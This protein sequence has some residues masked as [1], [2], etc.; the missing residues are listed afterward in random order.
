MEEI[1]DDVDVRSEV[2]R[3]FMDRPPSWL[4]RWGTLSLCVVL[5]AAFAIS[6]F[7]HYPTIVRTDFRLI[8]SNLPKAVLLKTDGRIE[9]LFVKENQ[10]VKV[11]EILAYIE[12]TSNHQQILP[13]K[14]S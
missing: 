3:D 1:Q 14:K 2:V 5:I 7:V 13:W 11:G 12:S 9:K 10:K 8:S 4:I 6:W